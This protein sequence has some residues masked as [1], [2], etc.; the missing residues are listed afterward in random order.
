MN[1]NISEMILNLTEHGAI[2]HTFEKFFLAFGMI[3]FCFGGMAAFPTI[4]ADMCR[5][6]KFPRTVCISMLG[7]G[8]VLVLGRV[9]I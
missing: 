7:E 4:Q 5:P 3:L 1:A 2:E 9:T 8:W 6:E